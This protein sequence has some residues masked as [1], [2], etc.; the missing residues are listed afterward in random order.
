MILLSSPLL[1]IYLYQGCEQLVLVGDHHQLP[2]TIK[3]KKAAARGL[4]VSLFSRL[5]MVGIQPSLLTLQYRMHPQIAYFPSKRFYGGLLKSQPKNKDRPRVPGFTWPNKVRRRRGGE[6]VVVVVVVV[7]QLLVLVVCLL[8]SPTPST[9][10]H[11]YSR[12]S[13]WPLYP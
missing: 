2:P 5:A 8:P 7:V 6:V 12:L 10:Y 11:Y 1:H 3:S 4:G 13:L 9:S